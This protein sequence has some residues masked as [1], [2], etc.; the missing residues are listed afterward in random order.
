MVAFRIAERRQLDCA[1]RVVILVDTHCHLQM[2]QY[3]AD[4]DAVISR[5]Q[6][7]NMRGILIGTC[8]DDSKS[9]VALAEQH[10]FLYAAIGVHPTDTRED[11]K[12]SPFRELVY[13][14]KVVA[15]GE[16]GLDYYREPDKS[17]Q[18]VL[19]EKQ[20]AFAQEI[21]KPVVV[22]CRDA[23][24]DCFSMLR[25][26][27]GVPFVLHTFSGDEKIA[28]KFLELGT[29]LSFSGIVTFDKTGVQERTV[30]ATPLERMMIE[31][32]APFLSPI[33]YR[34]KRNEPVYV[35]EIAKKIA[36]I[37]NASFET[38]VEQTG[39]NASNFFGLT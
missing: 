36:E 14:P 2:S 27:R 4:R 32:D 26:H 30:R 15:I 37:K 1:A 39:K 16:T 5:M 19:F 11:F 6:E 21:G 18:R 22:H 13:H 10:D 17:K 38:I 29:F 7:K 12:D 9:G 8:L 3:D 24:D 25:E 20:L 28:E 31:T 34:G 35:E 23:Y 33:P